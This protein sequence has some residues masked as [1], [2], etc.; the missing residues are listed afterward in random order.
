MNPQKQNHCL[1]MDN[2]WILWGLKLI[3]LAKSS[4]KILQQKLTQT[5]NTGLHHLLLL[6]NLNTK[7]L[8]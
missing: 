7:I 3:L 5:A 2:S 4:P 1:R 8:Y 6:Q